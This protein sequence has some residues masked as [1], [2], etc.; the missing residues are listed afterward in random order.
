[1]YFSR[2]IQQS[3]FAVFKILLPIAHKALN[4]GQ[5]SVRRM[6]AEGHKMR[7][8]LITFVGVKYAP[9]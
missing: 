7:V 6:C 2:E 4:V 5:V 8:E 1:M 9:Q 3:D